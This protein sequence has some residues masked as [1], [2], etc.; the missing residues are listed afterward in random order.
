MR[1]EQG[2]VESIITPEAEKRI[3]I[4]YRKKKNILTEKKKWEKLRKLERKK[5]K[6]K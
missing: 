2:R 6:R 3:K 1:R 5:R 4:F